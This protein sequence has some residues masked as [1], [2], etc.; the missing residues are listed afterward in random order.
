[1]QAST[2]RRLK[3]LADD[4]GNVSELAGILKEW[5]HALAPDAD[6]Q[7]SLTPASGHTSYPEVSLAP[8]L[9][10]RERTDRS[11]LRLMEE[12]LAKIEVGEPLPEGVGRL[13]EIV[14]DSGAGEP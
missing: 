12:I 7:T 6:V 10:L 5:A 2:E 14:G 8:A 4:L 3:E 1:V 9:I 11:L 13:V